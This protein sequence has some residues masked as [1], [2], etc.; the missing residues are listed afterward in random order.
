MQNVLILFAHPALEKSRVHAR[1]ING[2]D[3]MPNITFHDL[4][5]RYPD[6]YIDVAY[7]QELLLSHDIIILQHPFYWYSAPALVKQWIDLVLEH[8]WAYGRTGNALR[9]KVMLNAITAGGVRDAYGN[10]GYNRFSVRDFL[11]PF[12]QTAHL[13]HMHYWPPFVIHG[14]HRLSPEQVAEEVANYHELLQWLIEGK[15]TSEHIAATHY[16]NE[17]LVYQK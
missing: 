10:N 8:G 7:E 3:D 2:L 1:L 13:C 6:F 12:A 17:I 16:L 4:Y 9:G 11:L 14:T 15:I 5:Q